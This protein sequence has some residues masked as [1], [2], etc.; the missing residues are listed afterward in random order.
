MNTIRYFAFLAAFTALT[1][2]Q[3]QESAAPIPTPA[4]PELATPA[5]GLAPAAPD[6]VP[7]ADSSPFADPNKTSE[8]AVPSPEAPASAGSNPEAAAPVVAVPGEETF[9][10]D[11]VHSN[12]GF[13]VKH[14]FSNVAGR[15]NDFSGTITGSGDKPD[16]AKVNVQIQVAS[17]DTK[18]AKRDQHLR[19]DEFFDA[20][21]FPTIQ[22]TGKKVTRTGADSAFVTGDLT[23]RGVTKE[24]I[25][26]TK[27]LGRGKGMTGRIHTGWEGRTALKRSDYGLTWNKAIEGT[28]LVGDD[29]EIELQIEA[30]EP[31]IEPA[32]VAENQN[33]S[34]APAAEQP[35][36]AP[37]AEEP[38]APVA[39]P[40]APGTPEPPAAPAPVPSAVLQEA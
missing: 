13:R 4:T 12:V 32:P 26:Q 30:I 11:A 33:A 39:V 25:L 9:V 10:I 35:A 17:I 1:Q 27:F 3:A 29:I 2:S 8:I 40:P 34:E 15:F 28:Q 37:A 22:F 7:S 24:V 5:F 38:T 31:K 14:L 6:P 20:E 18:D 16:E 36:T 21:K 23:M 19:S